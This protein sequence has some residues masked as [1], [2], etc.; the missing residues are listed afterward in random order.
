MRDYSCVG[1]QPDGRSVTTMDCG[2]TR[3]WRSVIEIDLWLSVILRMRPFFAIEMLTFIELGWIENNAVLSPGTTRSA[4]PSS[5][6]ASAWPSAA[7]TTSTPP[8]WSPARRATPCRS[9]GSAGSTRGESSTRIWAMRTTCWHESTTTNY[10][11]WW[12]VQLHSKCVFIQ[13]KHRYHLDLMLPCVQI[14]SAYYFKQCITYLKVKCGYCVML[15]MQCYVSL[16]S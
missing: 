9:G 3:P 10:K 11:L 14:Q 6:A 1:V 13:T 12:Y 4:A 5:R 15:R 16:S 2:R 7:S 8:W